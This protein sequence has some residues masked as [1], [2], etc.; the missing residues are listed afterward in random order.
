[1]VAKTTNSIDML[2]YTK[3]SGIGAVGHFLEVATLC[4]DSKE[5]DEAEEGVIKTLHE[6]GNQRLNRLFYLI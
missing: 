4:G 1:M 6:S 3:H 2:L 5:H